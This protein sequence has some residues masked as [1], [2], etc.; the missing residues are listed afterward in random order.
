MP[1]D[2][3]E[4]QKRAVHYDAGHLL[5]AA[6]PGTGKTHTLTYRIARTAERLQD[7]RQILAVTFTNKA[8][9]EMRQRLSSRF[10]G[11]C[12]RIVVGT[13]HSFCLSCLRESAPADFDIADEERLEE[14]SRRLWPQEKRAARREKIQA[15]RRWKT[16]HFSPPSPEVPEDVLRYNSLLRQER[17]WDYDDLLLEALKVLRLREEAPYPFVFVD[18]YQD[19][20]ALQ[21][22]LLKELVKGETLLTAIGDPNQSIYGFRGGSPS[23]FES[24]AAD[25]SPAETLNLAQNYRSPANFVEASGQVAAKSNARFVPQVTADIYARGRLI[26]RECPTDK[27]EAEY[28]A[29]QIEKI[30]GGTGLFF[31]DSR[32][33]AAGPENERPFKDIAVL[34]RLNAQRHLLEK[35]LSRRG[36]PYQVCGE[37]PLEED[38]FAS[39]AEKVCLA[40]LHASKGLEFPVVFIIGCEEGLLPLNVLRTPS[41]PAEERRLF[42]VGMTRAREA[43]FLTFAKRRCL[44]G[45]VMKNSPSPYLADIEQHLKDYEQLPPP[46]KR[47]KESFSSQLEFFN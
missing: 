16:R 45:T 46:A 14:L 12:G 39:E 32:E 5:I 15:V 1:Q 31:R 47:R 38:R 40:T 4:S 2:L 11:A 17:L 22:A 10:P 18:E 27:A 3:N 23:F 33:V 37:K 34:Y 36:I 24:F 20:N 30:V 29:C 21:H 44:F 28:V 41:D 19:I 8:A 9:E 25:F 26:V 13:F 7:G 35:A 6:G 43:L 42:Y